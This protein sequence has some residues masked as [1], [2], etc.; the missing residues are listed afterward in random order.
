MF[1]WTGPAMCWALS[2][3]PGSAPVSLARTPGAATFSAVFR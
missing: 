1:R 2:V 3:V